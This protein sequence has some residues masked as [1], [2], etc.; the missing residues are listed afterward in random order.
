MAGAALPIELFQ[1]IFHHLVEVKRCYVNG[2]LQ[3]YPSGR[4]DKNSSKDLLSCALSCRAFSRPAMRVLWHVSELGPLVKLLPGFQIVNGC[5]AIDSELHD[6]TLERFDFYCTLVKTLV[7]SRSDQLHTSVET[8][9]VDARPR[10]LPSLTNVYCFASH[11]LS[12]KM[13]MLSPFLKSAHFADCSSGDL[14]DYLSSIKDEAPMLSLLCAHTFDVYKNSEVESFALTVF[15]PAEVIDR[16]FRSVISQWSR[17]LVNLRLQLSL[18]YRE[19]VPMLDALSPLF[20]L[21]R[22]ETFSLRYLRTGTPA[23]FTETLVFRI[24]DAW[25]NLSKLAMET[26]RFDERPIAPPLKTFSERLPKLKEISISLDFLHVPVIGH[27]TQHNEPPSLPISSQ[28]HRL[29]SITL[30]TDKQNTKRKLVTHILNLH[31]PINSDLSSER[32]ETGYCGGRRL[33]QLLEMSLPIELY[34]DIFYHL[35]QVMAVDVR[36]ILPDSFYLYLVEDSRK[37]LLS[38]SLTCKAFFRPAIRILWTAIHL[39]WLVKLLPGYKVVDGCDYSVPRHEDAGYEATDDCY[40]VKDAE[41]NDVSL[42]R[43][44]LYRAYVQRIFISNPLHPS[45]GTALVNARPRPL[46]SL[47]RVYC[48]TP[49]FLSAK[50][51]ML[52]PFLKSAHFHSCS[53]EDLKVYLSAVKDEAPLLSELR[54]ELDQP[55]SGTFL[56]FGDVT[57]LQDLQVLDIGGAYAFGATEMQEVPHSTALKKLGLGADRYSRHIFT[58]LDVYKNSEVDSFALQGSL[59]SAEDIDRIFCLVISQSS[60]TLVNLRLQLFLGYQELASVSQDPLLDALSTLFSLDRIETFTLRYTTAGFPASFSETL[61]SKIYDAWPNLTKLGME[62][63]QYNGGP[64]APPLD[65]FSKRLPKLKKISIS[66][67]FLHVPVIGHDTQHNEPPTLPISSQSHRLENITLWVESDVAYRNFLANGFTSLAYHLDTAFPHLERVSIRRLEWETWEGDGYHTAASG[68]QEAVCS[69]VVIVFPCDAFLSHTS[70]V[71]WNGTFSRFAVL[72]SITIGVQTGTAYRDL[73]TYGYHLDTAFPHLK[74][75]FIMQVTTHVYAEWLSAHLTIDV[76]HAQSKKDLLSCALTCRAFFDPAIRVLWHTV[77][78]LPLL[79]LLPGFQSQGGNY[80]LAGQLDEASM[81]RVYSIYFAKVRRLILQDIHEGFAI[82]DSVYAALAHLLPVPLPHLTHVYCSIPLRTEFHGMMFMLSP[83]LRSVALSDK[84][85]SSHFA[86]KYL[87]QIPILE[88]LAIKQGLDAGYDLERISQMRNLR[89]LHLSLLECDPLQTLVHL[90]RLEDL[91]IEILL[92]KIEVSMVHAARPNCLKR[93]ETSFCSA[94][95][96]FE[97]YQESPLESLTL[98]RFQGE[99]EF[100]TTFPSIPTQWSRTLTTLIAKQHG[101]IAIDAPHPFSTISQPL[102][103]LEQ[104][105]VVKLVNFQEQFYVVDDDIS[106]IAHAWPSLVELEIDAYTPAANT[107]RFPTVASLY[108][109]SRRCPN[110]ESVTIPFGVTNAD[111]LTPPSQSNVS[112]PVSSS[113]GF[114]HKLKRIS[115]DV[116]S[117]YGKSRLEDKSAVLAYHL[118]SAFPYLREVQFRRVGRVPEPW[119]E[120]QEILKHCQRVRR[121]QEKL[122]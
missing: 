102:C 92:S 87:H 99:P 52:S 59:L 54:V 26:H 29:E 36:G 55:E 50:M 88:S 58:L 64:I 12:T 18:Q 13:F 47:N 38:C 32:F 65:T 96:L 34:E 82:R 112:N 63:F 27:D 67:D 104:L 46:P 110:L 10:P 31:R 1:D 19:S 3:N 120:V 100:S 105:R 17:T 118:H 75:V 43:F 23:F 94:P 6:V 11:F 28:N 73:R 86:A 77:E 106:N 91:F 90:D 71:V 98:S 7:I 89:V 9:L 114:N 37:D 68:S 60:R 97:L 44:D 15:L 84:S 101:V 121:Q 103:N 78:L 76:L 93:L 49:R 14:K 74:H 115:F 35:I 81:E 39:Q 4:L 119:K 33:N 2:I 24:C 83:H 57:Q 116:L 30:L 5:Y 42:E 72:E 61:V 56:E 40:V 51:F 16:I 122:L 62:I 48:Y 21:D 45:V 69:E 53:R 117:V 8:A 20:S 22:I 41:L 109:L 80:V 85:G 107:Q 111:A 79:K 66:L 113:G 108:T 95:V 25:P 70:P